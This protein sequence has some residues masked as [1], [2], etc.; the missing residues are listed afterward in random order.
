[1]TRPPPVMRALLLAV[2]L[3]IAPPMPT[4]ALSV[5]DGANY[6]QNLLTAVRSLE[7]INNPSQVAMVFDGVYMHVQNANRFNLR[8][9]N[10]TA[11]NMTFADGHGSTIPQDGVYD[12][13]T[14]LYGTTELANESGDLADFLLI[15]KALN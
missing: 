11:L 7:Q 5:F 1:M 10:E 9:A 2:L 3:A 6:S 15:R 14:N 4:Q 8:H 13:A 12:P